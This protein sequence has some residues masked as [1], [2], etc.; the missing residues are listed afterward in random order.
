MKKKIIKLTEWDIHN[1]VNA[2][3][4]RV[5]NENS[6]SVTLY[7]CNPY[8]FDKLSNEKINNDQYYKDIGHS[9]YFTDNN[10]QRLLFGKPLNINEAVGGLKTG[11]E[12]DI[13]NYIK[14]FGHKGKL[15]NY[16]GRLIDAY[17]PYMEEAYNWAC[18]STDGVQRDGFAFFKRH[19][20]I[21]IVGRF[22]YNKRGLIY[23]ERN[24]DIDTNQE[25]NELGFKSIG[26][27]WSWKKNNA[28]SYC[29]NHSIL[30]NGVTTVT[31]CGYVHPDS[32]NWLETIYIN[33]YEMANET[34]IRMNNN[35]TVECGYILISGR[36]FPMG[37][38]YLIDASADKY[39]P[40]RKD[41]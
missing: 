20:S 21:D 32:I 38:T 36:K 28:S 7:H 25:I 27:C 22:N 3:V 14:S 17:G 10:R 18:K 1:M 9:I 41:W 6:D 15:P 34:E 4:H 19:F 30:N 2:V 37:G 26:E 11:Y 24:I 13:V 31:I 5:L 12:Q 23:V 40:N 39:N 29:S 35:A 8:F 16:E 33:S